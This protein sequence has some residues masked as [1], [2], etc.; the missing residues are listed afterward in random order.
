M[1]CE[2][3]PRA[4]RWR[5]SIGIVTATPSHRTAA[6]CLHHALDGT[7]CA[8]AISVGILAHVTSVAQSPLEVCALLLS[9]ATAAVAAVAAVGATAT[10]FGTARQHN[11][12][13]TRHIVHGEVPIRQG[14]YRRTVA[15]AVAAIQWQIAVATS[16]HHA[17]AGSSHH[18]TV[19]AA[20][21]HLTVATSSH[22]TVATSLH[23]P[24]ATSHHLHLILRQ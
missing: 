16:S 18:T 6:T 13:H 7:K 9:K 2:A 14:A 4:F 21:H 12:H 5:C 19:A 22:H 1:A 23:H 10:A 17:V 11:H 15:V 8:G 3:D 24:V 20:S